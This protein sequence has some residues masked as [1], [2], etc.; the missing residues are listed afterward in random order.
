MENDLERELIIRDYLARQRTTLA[1]NRTLLS[2]IRTALYFLVSGTAL[3]E[4]KELDHVRNLGYL[5]FVLS[6]VFLLGGF[7]SYFRI[8]GKLKKGNYLNM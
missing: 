3:F 2:F 6:F 5:A 1:N 8:R 7:L 4:V